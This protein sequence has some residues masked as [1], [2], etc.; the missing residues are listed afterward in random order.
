MLGA[1]AVAGCAAGGPEAAQAWALEDG[2]VTKAEYHK[3]VGGFLTC[4]R[5]AGYEVTEPVISPMDGLTLLYDIVPSGEPAAWNEKLESCNHRHLS[6]IEPAYVEAIEHVMDE[7]LRQGVAQCLAKKG[8]TAKGSERNA[9]DFV[10]AS[11][12]RPLV[13]ME[14]VTTTA[15]AIFPG[16]PNE[17]KV[18]Y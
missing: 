3:A 6:H 5:E 13:V 17:L 2:V 11:G 15:R 9:T 12:N 16:L 14:C 8:I 10:A 4:L 7:S 1:L 18:V